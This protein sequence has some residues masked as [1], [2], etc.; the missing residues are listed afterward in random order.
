M[1]TND[2]AVRKL[3]D[4]IDFDSERRIKYYFEFTF[5]DRRT[6]SSVALLG[7]RLGTA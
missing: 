5:G 6:S 3:E 1:P 2:A 4:D 7:L